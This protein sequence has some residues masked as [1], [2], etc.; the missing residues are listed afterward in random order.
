MPCTAREA[1]SSIIEWASPEKIDPTRKITIA[2]WKNC[3]RPYRSP[4]F[5]HSG[6]DAVE[7]SRY[8]VTT[9]DRWDSPCRSP[10]IVGSAVATIVWSSAAS[11]MP[12]SSAPMMIS[13]RRRPSVT[14]PVGAGEVAVC[15]TPHPLPVFLLIY[16]GGAGRKLGATGS[17]VPGRAGSGWPGATAAG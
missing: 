2:A 8:A 9:Q 4:S 5:P 15:V 14:G 1:I 7:A 13:T 12:S 10:A 17:A 16:P 6:V 3:L 11:S